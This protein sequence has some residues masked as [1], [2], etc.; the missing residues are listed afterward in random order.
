[1]HTA[2]F[3][4]WPL[5]LAT[6]L[7]LALAVPASA[8]LTSGPQKG[9]SVGAFIVTKVAGNPD[10]GVADGKTLC[11]RCKMGS[12]PVVMLFARTGD[13]SLAKLVKELEEEIAEHEAQKLTGFV[14]MIGADAESLKKA[15]ADFV[16]KN[17]IKKVA[18]VVPEDTQNGPSDFKIAPSADLTVVCYKNGTVVANHAFAA[19]QL[20]GDK[21]DAIVEA[22]CN[23][24]D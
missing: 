10:D 3:L 14:N 15:A 19:G 18:F 2:R 22:A 17:G 23:L 5:T 24:V 12:R 6:G 13:A 8:E 21:I 1:M 4:A 9:D 7:L 11:Y 16:S 20:N